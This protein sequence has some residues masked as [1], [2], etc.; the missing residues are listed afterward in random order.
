MGFYGSFLLAAAKLPSDHAL[1]PLPLSGKKLGGF[2]VAEDS[3]ARTADRG[4]GGEQAA[5]SGRPGFGTRGELRRGEARGS[6]SLGGT[7]VG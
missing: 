7:D 5:A 1:P 3:P 4:G 2:A 6:E